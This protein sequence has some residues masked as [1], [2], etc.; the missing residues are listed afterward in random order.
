MILDP[1]KLLGVGNA[2]DVVER[3]GAE[4][5]V[6]AAGGGLLLLGKFLEVSAT[7]AGVKF[8]KAVVAAV[9]GFLLLGVGTE[10]AVVAVGGGLLLLGKFLKVS[11]TDAGVKF[12]KAVV[13]AVVG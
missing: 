5:A 7:D 8:G 3:A 6:V 10:I 2:A 9:V 13:A 12:G 1:S 4:L 11:G